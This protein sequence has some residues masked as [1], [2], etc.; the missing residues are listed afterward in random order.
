MNSCNPMNFQYF[1]YKVEFALRGAGHIHGVLWV[2]WN[3]SLDLLDI[4]VSKIRSA[5][6]KIKNEEEISPDE[7]KSFCKFADEFISCSLKNPRVEEIV[8]CVNIHNHTKTCRKYS[9]NCR[10]HFPKFPSLQTLVPTPVRMLATSAEEQKRLINDK[11]HILDKVRQVLENNDLMT[12]IEHIHK[13]QVDEYKKIVDAKQMVERILYDD[14]CLENVD[15]RSRIADMMQQKDCQ[16]FENLEK[17]QLELN[18]KMLAMKINDI[19]RDR[20]ICLLR[21]AGL[22][23]ETDR[24]MLDNYHK[25]LSVSEYGYRIVHKRDIDEIF[26][27]NYNPEWIL[28]WDANMDIQLCLDFFAVVTYISDYYSKDDSGTMKHIQEALQ[29]AENENLRTKLNLVV[30][31]FLT[32]RQIGESEAFY[33]ILPHLHMRESNVEAVFVQTGFLH[34]RSKFLQKLSDEE[35]SKCKEPI[36]IEGRFGYYIE[37]PSMIDKYMRRD[38]S[39]HSDIFDI[40]YMQ[41]SKRYT[42]TRNA[43][44]NEE[45]FKP[46]VFSRQNGYKDLKLVSNIDFII[47]DDFDERK[48]LKLLPTFI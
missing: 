12:E 41:F 29:K 10:F 26:V 2:D 9:D 20:L 4:D 25:A 38:Y 43:P 15:N 5:L 14:T 44:K 1:S 45:K 24:E 19:L 33:R 7:E 22:N 34:N 8:R 31:Q 30:H 32:H 3:R 28:S 16:P 11:K 37:K 42:V 36:T 40:T 46:K 39:T 35:A 21:K 13:E 23:E 17:L 6:D 27:N 48:D 18:E 47:T